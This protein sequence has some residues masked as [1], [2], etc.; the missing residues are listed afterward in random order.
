MLLMSLMLE[1]FT[2]LL[3]FIFF[4]RGGRCDQNMQTE[5]KGEDKFVTNL[6][7]VQGENSV[8]VHLTP[9]RAT[10]GYFAAGQGVGHTLTNGLREFGCRC[11]CSVSQS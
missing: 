1:K 5:L 8:G 9:A 4:Q 6:L 7:F 3:C 11:G 10:S 2:P